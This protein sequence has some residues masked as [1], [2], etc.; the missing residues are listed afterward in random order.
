MDKKV[1][2]KCGIEKDITDFYNNYMY[3]D[4]YSNICKDCS[5]LASRKWREEHKERKRELNRLYYERRKAEFL[6]KQQEG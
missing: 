5:N 6:R 4:N 1:C 3:K 2:V